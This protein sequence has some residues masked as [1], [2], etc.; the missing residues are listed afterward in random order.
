MYGH[1]L[2]LVPAGGAFDTDGSMVDVYLDGELA[3]GLEVVWNDASPKAQV[4]RDLR[5]RIEELLAR[6]LGSGS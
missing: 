6:E 2:V 1:E 3:G 5:E 4:L